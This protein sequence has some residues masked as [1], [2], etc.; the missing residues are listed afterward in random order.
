MPL[1]FGEVEFV[2][3]L[4][5]L[6]GEGIWSMIFYWTQQSGVLG[7]KVRHFF[8]NK[9]ESSFVRNGCIYRRNVETYAVHFILPK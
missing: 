1:Q 2:L 6:M 5:M 9:I 4:S 7:P 3:S 8:R